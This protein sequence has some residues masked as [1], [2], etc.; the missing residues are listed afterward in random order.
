MFRRRL[1]HCAVWPKNQSHVFGY[2]ATQNLQRFFSTHAEQPE[3]ID[4]ERLIKAA[5]TRCTDAEKLAFAL[6]NCLVTLS[7]GQSIHTGNYLAA[8]LTEVNR[9]FKA[10]TFVL[11]DTLQRHTE[12]LHRYDL[13]LEPEINEQAM[14]KLS[15][16]NGD[17]WLKENFATLAKLNIPWKITR[18]DNWLK[19]EKYPG[20]LAMIQT[21]YCQDEKFKQAFDSNVEEYLARLKRRNELKVDDATAKKFCLAYLLEECAVMCLW[22]EENCQFELYASGRTQAMQETFD[23]FI[24]NFYPTLL[25][26]LAMRFKK[27]KHRGEFIVEAEN[28]DIDIENR[29]IMNEP[30]PRFTG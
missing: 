9:S 30:T 3:K 6:S 1:A 22:V 16:E 7:I 10:C 12:A 21:T 13:A 19:N 24:R 26:P 14:Y 2:K 28:S 17:K 27:V 4:D 11:G 18:W 25:H 23:R 29:E 5:F 20:M 8:T 15:R